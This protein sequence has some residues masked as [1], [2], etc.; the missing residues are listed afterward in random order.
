ME[1]KNNK[2]CATKKKLMQRQE[3]PIWSID[4]NKKK[5]TNEKK[6]ATILNHYCI[7]NI[8]NSL[9]LFFLSKN[10]NNPQQPLHKHNNRIPWMHP[11]NHEPL[12]KLWPPSASNLDQPMQ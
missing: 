4:Q 9:S 6:I 2:N 10:T 3:T 7:N 8:F 11:K 5:N 1:K 12:C